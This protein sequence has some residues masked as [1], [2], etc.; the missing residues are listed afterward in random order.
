MVVVVMVV[1]VVLGGMGSCCWVHKGIRFADWI[2]HENT[3]EIMKRLSFITVTGRLGV[4][5]TPPITGQVLRD[6]M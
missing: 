5:T 3:C 6:L 4:C 1:L 2:C